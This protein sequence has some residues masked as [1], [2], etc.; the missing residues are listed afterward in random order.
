MTKCQRLI[1]PQVSSAH[2]LL[3]RGDHR[4]SVPAR[5]G[6]PRSSA[7]RATRSG[8]R[9]RA[10]KPRISAFIN[11]RFDKIEAL[12]AGPGPG[13]LRS[14][15][16]SR[17]GADPPR[18]CGRHLQPAIGRRNPAD[19][20]DAR[21]PGRLSA[22][23]P[24]HLADRLERDL[25]RIRESAARFPRRLRTFFEEWDDPLISGIRWVEELVEIAG[26]APIFPELSQ[27]S[28]GARSH[29][30][31]GRS[32]AARPGSD[33]RLVVREEDAEGDDPRPAG[34][35]RGQRRSATIGSSR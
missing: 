15:G 24:K 19:D 35:G 22:T 21:R 30:R 4:D 12:R 23:P 26:G 28:L 5:P 1:V 14:P 27:A 17:G 18:H 16:G 7:S 6:R 2:R 20:P 11:A 29:R 3:D 9:R 13:L 31:S 10:Q 25:D 33:H 8:R 32:G 34:L